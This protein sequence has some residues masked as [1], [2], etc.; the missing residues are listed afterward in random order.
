MDLAPPLTHPV[1]I[2]MNWTGSVGHK[3]DMQTSLDLI[4]FNFMDLFGKGNEEFSCLRL[5]LRWWEN[6]RRSH[7]SSSFHVMCPSRALSMNVSRLERHH[8][9][10]HWT[11]GERGTIPSLD[12]HYSTLLSPSPFFF[13][14]IRDRQAIR[15]FCVVIGFG[16]LMAQP[17]WLNIKNLL[18][19]KK[20]YKRPI[21]MEIWDLNDWME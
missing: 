7:P 11:R 3:Y 6:R 9:Q 8:F 14:L 19:L 21:L 1:I 16:I 18:F 15:L 13:R 10:L 5:M 2:E 4:R 17:D 20:W 12:D